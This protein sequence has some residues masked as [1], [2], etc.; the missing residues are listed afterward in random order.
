MHSK[1]KGVIGELAVAKYLAENSIPV[2]TEL[3]DNS[4]VDLIALVN[5]KPILLQVKSFKT[6]NGVVNLS[7]KKSGPG[8]QF[9]Y[10][11]QDFDFIALHVPDKDVILWI[12]NKL[13]LENESL[14]IRFE[15][16]KNGQIK[17]IRFFTDYLKCPFI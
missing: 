7:F 10:D 14:S 16:T 3:G 5:R 4:K 9:K 12:E 1:T 11:I 6:N 2:F 15:E 17:N 8:Y 13:M